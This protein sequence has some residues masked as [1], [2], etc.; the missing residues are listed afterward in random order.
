MRA[1]VVLDEDEWTEALELIIERDYFPDIPKMQNKLEW[2]QVRLNT[3]CRLHF[4]ME[5]P[6]SI[7]DPSSRDVLGFSRCLGRGASPQLQEPCKQ[8]S[9]WHCAGCEEQG[10]R[11]A[12]AGAAEH[13]AAASRHQ[14]ACGAVPCDLCHPGRPVQLQD[15]R[16]P[17]AHTSGRTD[18]PA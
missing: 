15:A 16:Q 13:S 10:S 12:A 14:D 9:G 1:P 2:L 7:L 3:I 11:A 5:K 17:A 4:P 18:A 8:L 6:V